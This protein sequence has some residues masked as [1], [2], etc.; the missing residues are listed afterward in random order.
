MTVE[1]H[2]DPMA[3]PY[4]YQ[5]QKHGGFTL[6]EVMVALVIFSI[7]AAT[8][9]QQSGRST[10]QQATLEHRMHSH[11]IAENE[12]EKI[13]LKGFPSIG[14]TSREIDFSNQRWRIEQE[15]LKTNNADLRKVVI[16]VSRQDFDTSGY[17]LTGFLGRY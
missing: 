13:R 7:C 5:R 9:I 16:A 14:K 17:R 12:L 10:R 2:A 3:L 1:R 15:V 11:W 8:L 6:L 4:F